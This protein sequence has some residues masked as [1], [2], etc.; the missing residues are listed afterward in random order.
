VGILSAETPRDTVVGWLFVVVQ[1][2]LLAAIVL[3]GGGQDWAAPPWLAT[4]AW[5]LQGAGVIVL[6]TGLLGLGRSLT[7][8]PSPVPHGELRTG[9]PYRFVR[10]PIY[11]GIM[12]LT[13]GFAVRSGNAVVAATAVALVVWLAIKSRWEEV[14]L[15]ARYE[16]YRAYAARTPR[17]VPFWPARLHHR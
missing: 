15:L 9:G 6:V 7:A 12:A 14:R 16:G 8:L 11:S 3:E 13:L 5:W 10:H 1:F 4:S 2:A 17:F